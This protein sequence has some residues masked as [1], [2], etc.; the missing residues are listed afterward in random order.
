MRLVL[1][2]EPPWPW[3]RWKGTSKDASTWIVLGT[4]PLTSQDIG[5]RI[6]W[7][8]PA[9]VCPYAIIATF[10]PRRKLFI[11]SDLLLDVI[12]LEV[13]KY[14]FL[15][16]ALVHGLCKIELKLFLVFERAFWL[17]L[18]DD[19]V[20]I[21]GESV[22]HK[23]VRSGWWLPTWSPVALCR[24]PTSPSPVARPYFP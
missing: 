10:L 17:F 3:K 20:S 7:V 5:P 1:Q 24:W 8:F 21:V 11:N 13:A 4:S 2:V 6:V 9:P 23:L 15:S 12:V 16:S 22:F 19:S 14:F 18:D